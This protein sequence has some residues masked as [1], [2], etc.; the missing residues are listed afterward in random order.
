MSSTDFVRE[1][2]SVL[3]C[4]EEAGCYGG[5]AYIHHPRSHEWFTRDPDSSPLDPVLSPVLHGLKT[6]ISKGTDSRQH[7]QSFNVFL[8]F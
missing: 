1:V 8:L 7:K 5:E 4:F 6:R 2:F 3:I